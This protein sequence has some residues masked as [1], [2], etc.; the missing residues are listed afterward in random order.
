M[1]LPNAPGRLLFGREGGKG[2][3]SGSIT[4]LHYHIGNIKL[5]LP[6]SEVLPHIR[7]F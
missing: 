4:K 2:G 6:S 7:G 1:V 5:T 3:G